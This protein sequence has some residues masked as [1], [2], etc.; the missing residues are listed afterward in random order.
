[1]EQ[2]VESGAGREAAEQAA[3][4]AT[5]A[6][7]DG[8]NAEHGVGDSGFD[9]GVDVEFDIVDANDFASVNVDD[10]L[11]EEIALEQEQAFSAVGGGPVR[12]IG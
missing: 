3:N 8:L 10:L 7:I 2:E 12:G 1:V 5:G 11:V 9:D 6:D 4:G